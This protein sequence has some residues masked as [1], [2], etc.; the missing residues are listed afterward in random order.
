MLPLI[1]AP[2]RF[3]V[4][5]PQRNFQNIMSKLKLC[6]LVTSEA[7]TSEAVTSEAVT[8]EAVLY[9]IKFYQTIYAFSMFF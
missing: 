9:L 3:Y 8:S 5:Y 7:V 6:G 4:C 1:T 2:L